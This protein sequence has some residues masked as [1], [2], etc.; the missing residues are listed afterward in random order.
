M[1]SGAGRCISAGAGGS[2]SGSRSSSLAL[3]GRLRDEALERHRGGRAPRSL[4]MLAEVVVSQAVAGYGGGARHTW[5]LPACVVAG[6]P[7]RGCSSDGAPVDLRPLLAAARRRKSGVDSSLTTSPSGSSSS[8]TGSSPRG[9]SSGPGANSVNT[10]AIA[11]TVLRLDA[12]P[13]RTLIEMT[14]VP[15]CLA[16]TAAARAAAAAA[17]KKAATKN[18]NGPCLPLKVPPALE[19]ALE[20]GFPAAAELAF[21]RAADSAAAAALAEVVVPRESAGLY[22]PIGCN[23][24][25][26]Q[27]LLAFAPPAGTAA[28]IRTLGKRLN[29]G[30]DAP[31]SSTGGSSNSSSSSSSSSGCGINGGGPATTT[32]RLGS[33]VDA[34]LCLASALP[35]SAILLIN[36]EPGSGTAFCN[37][38]EA[39]DTCQ[40]PAASSRASGRSSWPDGNA[41]GAAGS[42]AGGGGRPRSSQQKQW[43]QVRMLL[44]HALHHWL[45]ALSQFTRALLELPG[46]NNCATAAE[47]ALWRRFL[48]REV[49][50]VPLLGAAARLALQLTSAQ[51]Q[52]YIGTRLAAVVASVL[53]SATMAMQDVLAEAMRQMADHQVPGTPW[54][55]AGLQQ[56]ADAG[57]PAGNKA[58]LDVTVRCMGWIRGFVSIGSPLAEVHSRALG[59][60]QRRLQSLRTMTDS[61][62]GYSWF[63][64]L[65]PV[66]FARAIGGNGGGDRVT[67]PSPATVSVGGATSTS[68]VSSGVGS[69]AGNN[70]GRGS[71]VTAA[72]A[73]SSLLRSCAH[74]GCANLEGGSDAELSLTVCIGCKAT[75]YCCRA[76]RSAHWKAGHKELCGVFRRAVGAPS[77]RAC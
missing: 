35:L 41:S 28:I 19:P 34:A 12:A 50:V 48:L 31:A 30:L 59:G 43:E 24:S 42:G 3:A 4:L 17:E 6:L 32:G 61:V 20:V 57:L 68:T 13:F 76:C 16:V 60:P 11:R 74:L 58:V 72:G 27:Q 71:T 67:F 44:S 33:L 49:E 52:A 47:L 8:G 40:V 1:N 46:P 73:P 51:P 23:W 65:S 26:L 56:L 15:H 29:V 75:C 63:L 55:E 39:R 62:P 45:P 21:R 25:V 18:P 10:G 2:S 54:S 22:D 66:A 9:S 70:A 53:N 37:V 5:G 7:V 69:N 77:L 38:S 14:G 36:L 64:P